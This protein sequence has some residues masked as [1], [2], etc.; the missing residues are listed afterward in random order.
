[1]DTTTTNRRDA[2]KLLGQSVALGAIPALA[3]GA[4]KKAHGA[5]IAVDRSPWDR[6][7]A[8]HIEAKRASDEYDA[9]FQR[10]AT[11]YDAAMPSDEMIDWRDFPFQSRP[12]VLNTLDLDEYEAELR[13]SE[14]KTWSASLEARQRRFD[15][16]NALREYR[17]LKD[18]ADSRTGYS[19]ACDHYEQLSDAACDAAWALFNIPAPDLEAFNWK[20][21][22]LFGDEARDSEGGCS[23][24]SG[25]VMGVFMSDARRFLSREA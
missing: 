3:I 22:H 13:A 4:A 5:T 11:S 21:E 7:Y 10:V 20:L 24:W 18:E 17:R 16:I 12:Y 25:E 2:L 14:G 6:A 23:A 9:V 19:A 15:N 8:A 1:M